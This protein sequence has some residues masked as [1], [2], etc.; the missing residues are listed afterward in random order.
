MLADEVRM[1]AY[2]EALRQCVSPRSVVL[3]VGTGPGMFALLACRL[4]ARRVYAVDP[5]DYVALGQALAADNDCG[6]R[7]E[8]LQ[9][10]IE[11]VELPAPV[12]VVV[13]DMSGVLPWF[14]GN[15]PRLR[16]VRERLLRPGGVMVP[17]RDRVWVAAVSIEQ[18]YADAMEPWR[19]ELF[20]LNMD[21]ARQMMTHEPWRHVPLTA[22]DLV[23][24]PQ[25]VTTLDYRQPLATDLEAEIALT[26]ERSAT[27]HG[28]CLWFDRETAPGFGFSNAPGEADTVYG[29]LVLPWPRA[30]P[31][32]AGDRI[33]LRLT[34]K[35]TGND[36]EWRW[37]TAFGDDE[38]GARA[39]RFDQSSFF[40]QPLGTLRLAMQSP[41]YRTRLNQDGLV[42]LQALRGLEA[43]EPIGAIAAALHE[44]FPERFPDAAAAHTRVA[45]LA[46]RYGEK[47][48]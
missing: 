2:T 36:Y 45:A 6:Q 39:P 7:V 32:T 11:E 44:S 1:Q 12:D 35:L 26:V 9:A 46:F 14:E 48:E 19:H 27:G 41:E 28:L 24:P 17:Q 34:A 23:T 40:A 42:D 15:L 22:D 16:Q 18:S 25:P 13:S 37:Q 3:D 29:R 5:S 31:L 4:G 20:G 47:P 38:A 21:R 43:G 10:T 33:G 30:V 8:F